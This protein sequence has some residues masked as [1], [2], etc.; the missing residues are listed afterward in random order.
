MRTHA[1]DDAIDVSQSLAKRLHLPSHEK[2]RST[3]QRLATTTKPV[4]PGGRLTISIV[5]PPTAAITPG[6]PSIA[7]QAIAQ[8]S[9]ERG[10]LE[11]PPYA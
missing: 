4:T 5:G 11:C 8:Q 2:V 6:A 9:A 1:S 3:T 7:R 10:D